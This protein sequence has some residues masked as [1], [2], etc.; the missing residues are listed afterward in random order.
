M[1]FLLQEERHGENPKEKQEGMGATLGD[2]E[3]IL[4]KNRA[5]RKLGRK[6]R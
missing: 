4:R 2:M 6:T 5:G 1:L 3:K